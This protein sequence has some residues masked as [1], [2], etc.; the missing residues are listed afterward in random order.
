MS[1]KKKKKKKIIS[2]FTVLRWAAFTAAV[3]GCMR[4]VGRGLDTWAQ[5]LQHVKWHVTQ[6]SPHNGNVK[7]ITAE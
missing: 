6:G 5:L 3:L 2:E 1:K 4:A 7:T